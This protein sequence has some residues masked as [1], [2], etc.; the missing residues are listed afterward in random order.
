M[1]FSRSQQPRYAVYIVGAGAPLLVG[2]YGSLA[3]CLEIEAMWLECGATV[4]HD[5]N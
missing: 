5:V 4:Y 1:R 3:R 2:R